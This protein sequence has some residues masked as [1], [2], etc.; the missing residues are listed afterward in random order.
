MIPIVLST[1]CESR[2]LQFCQH[3]RLISLNVQLSWCETVQRNG[4]STPWIHVYRLSRYS[5]HSQLKFHAPIPSLRHWLHSHHSVCLCNYPMM[6]RHSPLDDSS[7]IRLS[8]NAVMHYL[9]NPTRCQTNPAP[10]SLVFWVNFF[11]VVFLFKKTKRG[12]LG[13]PWSESVRAYVCAP[14]R[15]FRPP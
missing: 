15:K 13:S 14:I 9:T 2:R 11:S 3:A 5:F 10:F 4:S 6:H 1:E 8:R 7:L 12:P